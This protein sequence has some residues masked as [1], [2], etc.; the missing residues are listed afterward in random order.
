MKALKNVI[1]AVLILAMTLSFVACGGGNGDGGSASG[2]SGYVYIPQYISTEPFAE[3][4]NIITGTG[5]MLYISADVPV[6]EDGSVI[7]RAEM[8]E[9]N[10]QMQAYYESMENFYADNPEAYDNGVMYAGAIMRSSGTDLILPETA[11]GY[12]ET[13]GAVEN[14]GTLP[15]P[16]VMD[17]TYETR[18][19]SVNKD[20]TGLSMLEDYRPVK[21]A[22]DDY[23]YTD[24]QDMFIGGD[25]KLRVLECYM[26]TIFDLP[27]DFDPETQN[28]YDYYVTEKRYY[29]VSTLSET[30]AELSRICLN[31]YLE[32]E[33]EWY[34]VNGAIADD[35]GNIL[36]A[37][38]MGLGC[39]SPSG[40]L[41]FRKEI[42]DGWINDVLLLADGRPAAAC[43][44]EQEGNILQVI[45]L[46]TKDW[47]ESMPISENGWEF[48]RGGG[49]FDFCYDNN[50]TLMGASLKDQTEAVIVNWLNSDINSSDISYFEILENGDV[51]SIINSWDNG[52]E[53]EFEFVRLAKTPASQVKD[54]TVLTL[55]VASLDYRMREAVL[56]FNRNNTDLRVEVLDYS[57]YN[58]K[59]DY[60]AGT[61][62]LNTEIISGQIPD[63]IC[64]S[65]LPYKQ[66]AGKG[67]LEDLYPYIDSDGNIGR[68]GLVSG[69]LNAM[70]TDGKLYYI[71][72]GFTLT[73][74]VGNPEVVG[75]KQGWTMAELRSIIEQNP[76]ADCPF[77]L[78]MTREGVFESLFAL[79][80]DD[81]LDWNTGEC[82]FDSDDFK[83]L[84]ELAGTFPKAEDMDYDNIEWQDDYIL[85]S[86]RRQLA[87]NL[88]LYDLAYSYQYAKFAC[89][90][91][92]AI[93]GYPASQGVGTVASISNGIAMTSSCNDK[94]GAWAFISSL[95][96]EEYQSENV[97]WELPINKK[98]Y[99]DRLAQAMEQEYYTDENGEQQPIHYG[100]VLNE[101]GTEVRFY[102][103]TEEEVQEIR[104]I[105][106]T[107]QFTA[108]FDYNIVNVVIEEARSYFNGEK[109]VDE[110]AALIQSRMNI[111]INEQR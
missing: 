95:L 50:G 6:R 13:P 110:A 49:G 14:D 105:V 57:V 100:S 60:S 106:D 46:Q 7:S 45:D 91:K 80:I 109:T 84:L 19:F 92:M 44:S 35:R 47:G 94:E 53:P 52:D 55:A 98:V 20:G 82:R 75:E 72:P 41:V 86:Q 89:G 9:Y 3:R 15:E 103:L 39:V 40:E 79:C 97:L 28:E 22:E 51:F 111:Y 43:Y 70:E 74:F 76:Q 26:E 10:N 25:G 67:L 36:F 88:S 31:D 68:E 107:I 108:D 2:D 81:Y 29:Y 77:G 1:C 85:M 48:R 101:D 12:I 71:A 64:I 69:V 61:T 16:P 58:N 18:I 104:D 38:D 73:T 21:V 65:E 90:G 37:D 34:Y 4:F 87:L 102:A 24:I 5:E 33:L 66:Y 54:R 62:K 59:D 17:Y 96:G 27:E 30:G 93:K 56:D 11:P 23:S 78:W 99:E 63:L 8:D 42:A 32:E 83:A